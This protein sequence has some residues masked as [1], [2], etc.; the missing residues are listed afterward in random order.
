[1][2]AYPIHILDFSSLSVV[3]PT[4]TLRTRPFA[5]VRLAKLCR[6]LHR[7]N[8][9]SKTKFVFFQWC[10]TR[11]RLSHS[12]SLDYWRKTTLLCR[13]QSFHSLIHLCALESRLVP[14]IHSEVDTVT[15]SSPPLSLSVNG[16]LNSFQS[17]H[18]IQTLQF[19][20]ISDKQ[21][22]NHWFKVFSKLKACASCLF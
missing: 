9:G 21:W 3:V 10:L 4:R 8:R 2:W 7:L 20:V 11:Q 22:G 6:W 19:R 13:D 15:L 18:I 17:W 12:C 16:S 5:P 1:M 14:C